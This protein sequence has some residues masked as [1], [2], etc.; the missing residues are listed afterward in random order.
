MALDKIEAKYWLAVASAEH[1]RLGRADGFMQLGHGKLAPL[2][3]VRPGDRIVYYSPATA[4][5]GKDKLQSLVAIGVIKDRE[6][7]RADLGQGLWLFRRDVAWK[8]AKEAPIAPLL[9]RLEL[10]RGKANR[11]YQLRF[12]L[13]NIG[14]RD[15][16]LI[17]RAMGAKGL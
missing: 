8:K 17:A 1:V 6:P 11:G 16:T 13:I 7:Y 15:M 2:K 4:Y 5:G 14:K 3:R 12:G 9:D 10:T